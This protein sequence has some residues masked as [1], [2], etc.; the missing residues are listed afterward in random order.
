MFS[1]NPLTPTVVAMSLNRCRYPIGG[2]TSF[3]FCCE[4]RIEGSLYCAQHN[5]L[6]HY[7]A[8]RLRMSAL[9]SQ[10]MQGPTSVRGDRPKLRRLRS[11]KGRGDGPTGTAP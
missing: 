1:E 4:D 11:L 10:H 6:S 7:A 8:A 9:A 2:G 5:K 3:A